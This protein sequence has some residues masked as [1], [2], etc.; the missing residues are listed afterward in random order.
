VRYLAWLV[1]WS[2]GDGQNRLPLYCSLSVAFLV[3]VYT[4]W[5]GG[6][7]WNLANALEYTVSFWPGLV[8]FFLAVLCSISIGLA[9]REI[10]HRRAMSQKY[11]AS[12]PLEGHL[13]DVAV[14]IF[15]GKIDFKIMPW[16]P[17]LP[18]TSCV[19][20]KSAATLVSM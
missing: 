9:A 18:S 10:R 14:P 4:V 16:T 7:P 6:F 1:P 2:A 11:L 17:F 12:E 20:W 5:S 3:T 15:A 8:L 13:P 19:M